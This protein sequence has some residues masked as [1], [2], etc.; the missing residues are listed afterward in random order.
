[1]KFFRQ[2]GWLRAFLAGLYVIVAAAVGYAHH[3]S[4]AAQELSSTLELFQLP[5]GSVP[6]LCSSTHSKQDGTH[7]RP[8]KFPSCDACRLSQQPGLGA[9]APAEFILP[10]LN[11]I[12]AFSQRFDRVP[13]AP[14]ARP[15]AR[16]PPAFPIYRM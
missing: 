12:W 9:I 5:D 11:T 15:N 10:E 1:M 16:G 13:T 6:D 7:D 14:F 4:A 8:D 2:N 3:A